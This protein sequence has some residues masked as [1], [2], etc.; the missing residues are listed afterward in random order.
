MKVGGEIL[1]NLHFCLFLIHSN[2]LHIGLMIMNFSLFTIY[3]SI[4]TKLI[5]FR[6]D[7]QHTI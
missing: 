3:S 4:L 5:L 1:E 7:S 2:I 6:F